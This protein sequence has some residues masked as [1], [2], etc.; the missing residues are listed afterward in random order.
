MAICT[1]PPVSGMPIE[2]PTPVIE[3]RA[4]QVQ[5]VLAGIGTHRV[6]PDPTVRAGV[7]RVDL[8]GGVAWGRPGS[9]GFGVGCVACVPCRSGAPDLHRGWW[10]ASAGGGDG[11]DAL[12]DGDGVLA[13]VQ[14]VV[15]ALA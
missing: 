14:V 3:D 2:Y 9:L 5:L 6:D 1:T 15:A 4:L 10:C 13:E 11:G 8:P 12:G 7:S